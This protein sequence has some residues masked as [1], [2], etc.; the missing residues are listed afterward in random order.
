MIQPYTFFARYNYYFLR[1]NSRNFDGYKFKF[2]ADGIWGKECEAVAKKALCKK[3]LVGYKNLT[4]IV[5]KVV[6][7]TADGKFGNDTRNAVIKWQKLVGL[8][9][10][11]VVGY[12]SWKK[13][14]S[15]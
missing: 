7:V 4:K 8:V 15:V 11:G 14:L 10:D 2:G 13:I 3:H 5:Q 9:A 6:G 1:W 12:N